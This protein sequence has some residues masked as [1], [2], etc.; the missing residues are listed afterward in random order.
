[1]DVICPYC[2]APAVIQTGHQLYFGRAPQLDGLKFWVCI[3]CSAW[4]GC[5]KPGSFH[6]ENG[7]KVFHGEAEPMGRLANAEL[8]RLKMAAHDLL[9][10]LWRSKKMTRSKVY[11]WLA[12][13]MDLPLERTHI[14]EFNE[15][16]CLKAL[17]ILRVRGRQRYD[18]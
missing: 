18:D 11:K 8:R 14:G 5:H 13:Q 17:R 4:V 6:M 3:P 16:Q 1:M 7:V 2:A 12:K 15:E 9:D 10:P